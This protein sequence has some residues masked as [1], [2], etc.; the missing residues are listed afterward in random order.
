MVYAKAFFDLQLQFAHKV[1][2]L[3]GLPLACVLLKYTNLYIRFGLGRDFHPA[4][5]TWQAYLAG[6]QDTNDQRRLDLSLLLDA[7]GGA[8]GATCRGHLWLLFIRAVAWRPHPPPLPECRHG[9]ALFP[10]RRLPGAATRRPDRPLSST[11]NRPCPS[12]SRWW[13]CRG[14]T[15]SRRI[16][17][18]FR[19][20]TSRRRACS[21]IASSPCHSGGNFWIGMEAS[22]RP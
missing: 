17:A 22:K 7:S 20:R 21:V 6:L 14:C 13:E 16:V 8:G 10:W 3:S 2:A 19:S 9:G 4:H 11:C 15:I 18:C 12:G 1:T 5:P